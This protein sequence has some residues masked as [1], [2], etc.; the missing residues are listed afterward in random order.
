MQLLKFGDPRQ[1]A[2]SPLA[3]ARGREKHVPLLS[4]RTGIRYA[5]STVQLSCFFLAA[6]QFGAGKLKGHDKMQGSKINDM[7]TLRCVLTWKRRYV[8]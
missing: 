5:G 2:T 3:E 4:S 8:A 7:S 1:T 6:V